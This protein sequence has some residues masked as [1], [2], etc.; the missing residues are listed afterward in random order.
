[1]DEHLRSGTCEP[2]GLM[3]QRPRVTPSRDAVAFTGVSAS[4]SAQQRA[5][6]RRRGARAPPTGGRGGG[7]CPVNREG[8]SMHTLIGR[9]E[10]GPLSIAPPDLIRVSLPT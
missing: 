3:R 9:L 8:M 4:A 2:I 1:M 6:A 10:L 5:R 7:A